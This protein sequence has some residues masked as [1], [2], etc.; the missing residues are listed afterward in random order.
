MLFKD[1]YKIQCY[2]LPFS[3]TC[4]WPAMET[5]SLQEG[6]ADT[7]A[8]LKELST[9]LPEYEVACVNY[10][11][12]KKGYS[13]ALV[14]L[15]KDCPQPV[16]VSADDLPSAIDEGR[17]VV[18]EFEALYVILCLGSSMFKGCQFGSWGWL[19]WNFT[20]NHRC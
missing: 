17:M 15:H 12:A 9:A 10:S 7:E 8:A 13:G 4:F 18:L 5:T 6:A 3:G 11:T 2:L 20:G 1:P 16:H 19:V 14:M